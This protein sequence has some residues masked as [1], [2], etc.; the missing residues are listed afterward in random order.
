[1]L[2]NCF[3]VFTVQDGEMIV[4]LFSVLYVLFWEYVQLGVTLKRYSN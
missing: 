3:F 4:L 2:I 1:M